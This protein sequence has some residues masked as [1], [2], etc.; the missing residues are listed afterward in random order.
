MNKFSGGSVQ[1]LITQ[2]SIK[3]LPI[4][5]LDFQFQQKIHSRLNESVELKKKSKQLLEI[6]TIGVEKAIE[7]DE[8]TATDWINQQLQHLD[9]ELTDSRRET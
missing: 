4:P 5:I 2:T 3:S 6:A 1:P 9:I 8:E 7:T